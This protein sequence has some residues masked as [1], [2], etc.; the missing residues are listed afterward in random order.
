MRYHEL[1]TAPAPG[2]R[3]RLPPSHPIMLQLAIDPSDWC[4][5][6]RLDADNP[7]TVILGHDDPQNGRLTVYIACAN[8][9]A[10]QCLEDGWG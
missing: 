9:R 4:R 10:R 5:F 3:F 7:A 2:D 1:A 6:Q 8:E